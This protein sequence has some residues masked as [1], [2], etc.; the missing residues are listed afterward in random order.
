MKPIRLLPLLFTL[1]A[2]PLAGHDFWIE[3]SSF[4]PAPG[5]DVTVRLLVGERLAGDAVPRRASRVR[6]FFAAGPGGRAELAGE[7]GAE[8]AGR[9][10]P[11]TPGL[12]ALAY[13]SRGSQLELSAR[14]FTAYLAEEGLEAAA[15]ERLRRDE[16]DLP[17]RERFTRHA[18]SLVAVGERTG[19]DRT[20]G[21]ALELVAEK[22]PYLLAPGE[23]L[24]LRL[25]ASGQP[26]AGAQVVARSRAAPERAIVLRTGA[27]GRVELPLDADGLWLIKAVHIERLENDPLAEWHSLWASLTFALPER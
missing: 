13:V 26:L 23:S 27:D 16:A 9:W 21:L 15:A 22:N 18:K 5:G 24:P 12:H 8:P 19:A 11:A 7:D 10:R 2:G 3:P 1:V 14:K 20:L 4:A 6:E 17:A 25:L